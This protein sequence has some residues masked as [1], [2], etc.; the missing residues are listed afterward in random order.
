MT[1][2]SFVDTN[3][4]VHSI[5]DADPEKHSRARTILTPGTGADLV[6][7]AQ[8]LGEFYVT[9][10]RKF[11][12]RVPVAQAQAMVEQMSRLPVVA[13][14]ADVVAAG[15]AGSRTWQISYWDALVIA[16]AASSG[17]SVV[18]S[19]DLA[20]G[21]RYGSVRVEDPFRQSHRVL[22][23]AEGTGQG[24]TVDGRASRRGTWDD[25][26][27][28]DE[29]S[30]YEQACRESGMRPNAVH[31]YWD[32]ARRFLDWRLGSYRPRGTSGRGRPVP[33]GAVTV[34][35]LKRQAQSYAGQV[36]AAGRA[37]ASIDTYYRH[38]MFFIRWLQGEFEPG[39]R[40]R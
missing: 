39:R 35:E 37:Q 30:R 25:A 10:T 29:L 38:A 3:V 21:A 6:V 1:D 32:Y 8:V 34:D 16:A 4:W 7:S 36:E 17:C 40:L 28:L 14:D 2:R 24:A 31:S 33:A 11:A 20:H 15:V 12:R 27:L 23:S 26:A 22:E 13:I 9:I 19:E 5:D 18:L